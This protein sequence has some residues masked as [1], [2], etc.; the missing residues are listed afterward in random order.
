MSE[1][2]QNKRSE[3]EF[4]HRL[5]VIRSTAEAATE[6]SWLTIHTINEAICDNIII[7]P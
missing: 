3:T 5:H 2:K 4:S 7:S 6:N 1:I